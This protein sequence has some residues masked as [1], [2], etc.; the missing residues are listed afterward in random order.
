MAHVAE[1][2]NLDD[3]GDYRPGLLAVAEQSVKSPLREA[4]LTKMDIREI[5]ARL[6]LPTADKQSFACLSSRFVYGETITEEKLKRVDRA[7]QALLDLGFTQV[8]VRIHGEAG[9]Q[10][11]IEVMPD[12]FARFLDEEARGRVLSAFEGFGFKYVSLDLGGYRTG[13]M[14]ATL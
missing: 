8:R 5:S 1:G 9:E 2:S 11:R 3:E 12:E 4:G 7:E 10:A 6:G 13:S 14:N